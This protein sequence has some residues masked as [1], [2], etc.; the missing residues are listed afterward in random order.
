MMMMMMMMTGSVRRKN[1]YTVQPQDAS[2]AAVSFR[3][4]YVPKDLPKARTD[5]SVHRK[6]RYTVQPPEARVKYQNFQNHSVQMQKILTHEHSG[7]RLFL[8]GEEE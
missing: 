4:R 3:K 2:E 6:N 5:E 7:T 1:R 8:C